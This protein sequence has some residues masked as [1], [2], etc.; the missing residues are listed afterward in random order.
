MKKIILS[1]LALVFT[2]AA[3]AKENEAKTPASID[4]A[5]TVVL[6]GSIADANSG[7]SLAGVEV[8]IEGTDYKTYSDFDGNFS[9]NSLK[10]GEYKVVTKYISYK[11]ASQTL[12]LNARETE[13]KIKMENPK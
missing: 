8:K 13:L 7:E 5:A 10:P 3:I 6:T 2:I 9:F 1:L 12:T 11:A 4:N